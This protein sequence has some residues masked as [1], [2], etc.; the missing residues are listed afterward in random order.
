MPKAIKAVL[1][2]APP[3]T[4]PETPIRVNPFLPTSTEAAQ[5]IPMQ[6]QELP[7]MM[8]QVMRDADRLLD[9]AERIMDTCVE[10]Q[11]LDMAAKMHDRCVKTLQL[12]VNTINA[13]THAT[14]SAVSMMNATRQAAMDAKKPVELGSNAL[15]PELQSTLID[16]I[17]RREVPV[18]DVTNG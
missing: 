13:F 18:M 3:K 6:Y 11:S 15:S 5:I 17:A 2:P 4:R 16:L 9:K 8:A 14:D 1:P 12:K 7:P 10:T